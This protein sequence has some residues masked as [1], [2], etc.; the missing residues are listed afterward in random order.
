MMGYQFENLVLANRLAL[1]KI[2][3]IDPVEVLIAN[4]YFQRKTQRYHGCQIDF[5][6]Q[7]RHRSL[8]VVEIKFSQSKE[9]LPVVEEV[10]EKLKHFSIPRGFSLRYVLIHVNGVTDSI[11]ESH[12]FDYIVDFS[13]FLSNDQ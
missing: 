8:Y 2:L 10:K 6:I 5:L 9:E 12:F 1:Y 3:Q 7:T 11:K 13:S 4:P